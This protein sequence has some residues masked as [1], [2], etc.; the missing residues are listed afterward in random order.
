M[1]GILIIIDC[2]LASF[3]QHAFTELINFVQTRSITSEELAAELSSA[4]EKAKVISKSVATY[5]IHRR[6]VFHVNVDV[7]APCLVLP[8]HGALLK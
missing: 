7:K 2:D 1:T 5:A 8:D 3:P 6:K 4:V